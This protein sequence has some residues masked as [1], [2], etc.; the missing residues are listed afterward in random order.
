MRVKL[1]HFHWVAGE[2]LNSLIYLDGKLMGGQSWPLSSWESFLNTYSSLVVVAFDESNEIVGF[3][4]GGVGPLGDELHILKIAVLPNYRRAGVGKM[5][6]DETF[7]SGEFKVF[8]EVNTNNI[9]ALK[10]YESYGFVK[11]REIKSFYSNGDNAF[12]MIKN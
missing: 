8:L 6:L 4:L 2:I 9:N 1:L 5:I 10:F 3:L 12:F 11:L 7:K